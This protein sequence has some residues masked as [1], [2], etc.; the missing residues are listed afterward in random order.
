[1]EAYLGHDKYSIQK[2][3]VSHIEYSGGRSRFR[4]DKKTSALAIA[5][6]L[7]DRLIEC[8]NDTMQQWTRLDA[9]RVYVM[10]PTYSLGKRIRS[11]LVNLCLEDAYR[12]A[13]ADLGIKIDEIYD[14]EV[15]EASTKKG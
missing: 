10:C 14:Y 13:L 6:S 3:F 15:E 12:E 7:R 2:H 8:W 5:K 1:M 11:V 9:K 4:F